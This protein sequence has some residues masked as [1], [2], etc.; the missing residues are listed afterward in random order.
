MIEARNQL[1]DIV[2]AKGRLTEHEVRVAGLTSTSLIVLKGMLA[3][4]SAGGTVQTAG[5]TMKL[6]KGEVEAVLALLTER[7]ENLLI[8]LDIQLDREGS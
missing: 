3:N 4:C 2:P 1:P 6:A 7:A 8:Y 5:G